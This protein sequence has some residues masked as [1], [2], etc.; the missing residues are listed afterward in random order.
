MNNLVALV[1]TVHNHAFLIVH[2]GAVPSTQSSR[3][4]A[5]HPGSGFPVN[6]NE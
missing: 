2:S 6:G 5:G 4:G 1:E 3:L